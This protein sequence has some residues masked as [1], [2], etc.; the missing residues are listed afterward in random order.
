MM[1]A[2]REKYALLCC[3]PPNEVS[4]E[5]HFYIDL[6]NKVTDINTAIGKHTL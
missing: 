4:Y 2:G 6:Q 1:Q 3:H 5:H